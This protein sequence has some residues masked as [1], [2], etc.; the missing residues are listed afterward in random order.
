MEQ[1]KARAP[2]FTGLPKIHKENTPILILINYT[3]A[4][5]YKIP[6]VLRHIINTVLNWIITSVKNNTEFV[7][8]AK[9]I[10]ISPNYK[11]TSYSIGNLYTTIPV[12]E[13][14]D[15]LKSNLI[16]STVLSQQHTDELL[17]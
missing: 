5:S 4:H 16:K 7:D 11:L 8:K 15:T 13:T 14:I 2:I 10:E 1:T 17:N 3:S 12:L 6:K 9:N